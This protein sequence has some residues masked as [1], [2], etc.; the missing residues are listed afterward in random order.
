MFQNTDEPS[1]SFLIQFAACKSLWATCLLGPDP[2]SIQQQIFRMLWDT[3]AWLVINESLL[4]GFRGDVTRLWSPVTRVHWFVTR[5]PT[6]FTRLWEVEPSEPV[7]A[8]NGPLVADPQTCG[9]AT[10]THGS[11]L[12]TC[13]RA[14]KTHG[15]YR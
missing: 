13:G 6:P 4:P 3:G 2:N 5:L 9:R 8:T 7:V 15:S 10:E 11:D 14:A 1:T 12:K